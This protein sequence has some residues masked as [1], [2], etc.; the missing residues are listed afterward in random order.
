MKYQDK[1]V[2]ARGWWEFAKVVMEVLKHSFCF[3]DAPGR[4]MVKS[5]FTFIQGE[6]FIVCL[7]SQLQMPP[8]LVT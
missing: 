2:S 5:E 3:V 1:Q 7:L 4:T 6:E 8:P